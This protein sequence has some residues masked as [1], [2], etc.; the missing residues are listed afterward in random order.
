[1]VMYEYYKANREH[2]EGIHKA[3]EVTEYILNVAVL[4]Y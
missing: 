4:Q 2:K 3:K 1:M